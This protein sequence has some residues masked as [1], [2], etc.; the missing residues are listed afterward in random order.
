VYFCV[1][2]YATTQETRQLFIR[3][4]HIYALT[5]DTAMSSFVLSSGAL[6]RVD[7]PRF[8]RG[9]V[10]RTRT[11]AP[12]V[13]GRGGPV[14]TNAFFGGGAPKSN[15]KAMVCIDCGTS[16][17]LRVTRRF[18][19]TESSCRMVHSAVA[20]APVSDVSCNPL[21]SKGYVYRGGDFDSLPKDWSCPPC[22]VGK[23]RFKVYQEGNA[24][25]QMAAQKKANKEAMAAKKKG[26]P[27]KRE[28]LKQKMLEEQ[29]Q[30]DKKKGGGF[31]GR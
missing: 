15:G 8:L 13:R 25:D 7:T 5:P 24:Y 6:A 21:S 22:G 17:S 29:A 2:V 4:S 20:F 19:A 16:R 23:N 1:C 30:M 3:A 26:G 10:L 12:A 27:S 11:G 9:G 14:K 18:P 31:F 28:L